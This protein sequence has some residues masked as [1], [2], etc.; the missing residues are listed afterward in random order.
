MTIMKLCK[1]C[2]HYVHYKYDPKYSTCNKE[3]FEEINIVTGEKTKAFCGIMRDYCPDKCGKEGKCWE[4]KSEPPLYR[5]VDEYDDPKYFCK[6][7][8]APLKR[9]WFFFKTDE[10]TNPKCENWHGK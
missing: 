9:K 8:Q 4:P 1:D 10:C 2:I 5:I 7:C 3:E 6:K